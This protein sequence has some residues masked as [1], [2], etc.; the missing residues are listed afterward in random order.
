MLPSDE[1]VIKAT[2]LTSNVQA[3]IPQIWAAR[4]EKNLRKLKVFEQSV[5]VNTDLLVPGAGDTVYIPIL[6]DLAAAPALTEGTDMVPIALNNA[7]SIPLK[8]QEYGMVV[9]ITRKALDRMKYD[10]VAEIIDRLGY[11]MSLTIEG[12]IASLYSAAVPG[13]MNTLPVLYANGKSSTTITNADTFNDACILNAVEVLESKNNVPFEDG[14][15]RLYISPSQW[16]SLLQDSNV[17]NSLMWADSGHGDAARL[18]DGY[19]PLRNERGRLHGCRIIVTNYIQTDVENTVTVQNA[20]LVAPRWAAIAYKRR[21]EVVV[22]PT[23]YDIGRRRRFGVVAD[24]DTELI[25]YERAV[26]IKSA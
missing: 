17:R 5:V 20:M 14:Y 11:G 4:L 13:T 26:V 10:G 6:P 15:Y 23:L 16:M 12:A 18:L 25:H 21:P 8:P 3:L 24:F 2:T 7:M 1:L 22:D 19:G 9:E